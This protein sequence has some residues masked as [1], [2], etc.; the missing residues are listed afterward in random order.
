MYIHGHG[1]DDS[2]KNWFIEKIE[3]IGWFNK[4]N[5]CRKTYV[6]ISIMFLISE[7]ATWGEGKRIMN[8]NGLQQINDNQF[9]FLIAWIKMLP[10]LN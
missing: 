1:F 3:Q 6:S 8:S 2:P 4:K 5:L 7:V 9:D 10:H